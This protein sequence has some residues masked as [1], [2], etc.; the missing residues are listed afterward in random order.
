M[1]VSYP[2]HPHRPAH[3]G[4]RPPRRG[5]KK[6]VARHAIFVR[7]GFATRFD[8]L[9]ALQSPEEIET[10]EYLCFIAANRL[11]LYT[12]L[13]T[14][15]SDNIGHFLK[16]LNNMGLPKETVLELATDFAKAKQDSP[17]K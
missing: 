14:Q 11:S 7:Y 13:E 8:A 12:P 9:N 1:E 4:R 6:K 16:R 17:K 2:A 3:D 15:V 10:L 5:G